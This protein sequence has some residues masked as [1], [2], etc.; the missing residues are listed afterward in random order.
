MGR[1]VSGSMAV[2]HLVEVWCLVTVLFITEFVPS[3]DA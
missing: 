1:V 3:D 2:G